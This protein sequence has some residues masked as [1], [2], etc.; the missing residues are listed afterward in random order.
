MYC[1]IND[2]RG[3]FIFFVLPHI[4]TNC[5]ILLHAQSNREQYVDLEKKVEH[6]MKIVEGKMG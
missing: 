4:I 5:F 1:Q 6:L 2:F 3:F